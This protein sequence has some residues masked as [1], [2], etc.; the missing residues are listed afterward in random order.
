MLIGGE[1]D[2]EEL[3]HSRKLFARKFDQDYYAVVDRTT[4]ALRG[5]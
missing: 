1:E 5:K 4:S 3:M 2:Y